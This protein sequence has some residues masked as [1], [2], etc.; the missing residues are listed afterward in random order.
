MPQLTL[1]TDDPVYGF[2]CELTKLFG[3]PKAALRAM[4]QNSDVF[5]QWYA[6]V[7]HCRNCNRFVP[8]WPRTNKLD[9]HSILNP[10]EPPPHWLPCPGQGKKALPLPA[11]D[12]RE[13]DMFR[14]YVE[15]YVETLQPGLL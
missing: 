10:G 5:R 9:E 8:F 1:A 11:L 14:V 6:K 7:R 4:I 3:T 2:L 13:L 15:H 12:L